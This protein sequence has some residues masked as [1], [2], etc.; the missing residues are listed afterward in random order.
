MGGYFSAHPADA[1]NITKS[2]YMNATQTLTN[3]QVHMNG[4]W[5]NDASH[6]NLVQQSEW[7][8]TRHDN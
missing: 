4:E 3:T 5:W 1:S 8:A 6:S 2:R 7:P